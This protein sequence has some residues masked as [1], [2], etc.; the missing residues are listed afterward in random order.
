MAVLLVQ[1]VR[2]V[3]DCVPLGPD[4]L[5]RARKLWVLDNYAVLRGIGRRRTFVYQRDLAEARFLALAD[6]LG[7]S[8]RAGAD[9]R[10][11]LRDLLQDIAAVHISRTLRQL[12]RGLPAYNVFIDAVTGEIGEPERVF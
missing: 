8:V 9:L 6:A 7:N 4:E 10:A 5:R 12:A 1:N 3:V 2:N 11:E